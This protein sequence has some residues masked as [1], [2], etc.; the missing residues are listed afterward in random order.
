MVEPISPGEGI[1]LA[2]AFDSE[3]IFSEALAGLIPWSSKIR[4]PCLSIYSFQ[5]LKCSTRLDNTSIE[6]K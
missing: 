6:F 2:P 5:S 3:R 1:M 4:R